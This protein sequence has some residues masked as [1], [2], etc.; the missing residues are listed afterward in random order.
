MDFPLGGTQM[1]RKERIPKSPE[2]RL[3]ECETHLYFLW[4]ARRLYHEQRD[5][6]K[7]IAAEL[8]VLV[9]DHKPSRRLLLS[10][11]EDFGF[12]YQVQPPPAPFNKQPIPMVGWRIDPNHR[13][14]ARQ[15]EAAIGDEAKM[16]EV[17]VAQ[18]ALRRPVPLAEYVEKGL[19]VYIAP[20][21]YSFR[22]LVLAIAQ[23]IGSGHEDSAVDA[24]LAKMG[25]VL[26]GGEESHVATLIKFAD[27][28]LNV[29]ALFIDHVAQVHGYSPKY[30]RIGAA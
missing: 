22:E 1:R 9:G 30:F 19:A 28:V 6:Y 21:D 13:L 11:M 20:H 26:L 25:N 15:V 5:R 3:V 14:L 23:Q 17:L 29:G 16:A 10:M 27:L 2:A 4:D 12:T 18:A 24:P 8:R 7:Q